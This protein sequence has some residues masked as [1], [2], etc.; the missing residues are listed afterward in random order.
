MKLKIGELLVYFPYEHIYPEQYFYITDL[1]NTLDA[2]GHSVLEMPSGTGKTISLLSLVVSYLLANPT[3]YTKL[4]YCSRTVPELDKV[5]KELQKLLDYITIETGQQPDILGIAL[6]S[7]KNL[8]VHPVVSKLRNSEL[9]NGKCY[10][11]TSSHN[12]N[13]RKILSNFNE[14]ECKPELCDFFESHREQ[15]SDF[16]LPN[17]VYRLCDVRKVGIAKGWCP[18]FIARNA[19]HSANVVVYSYHYLLDPK[20]SD[21]VS[22]DIGPQTVVVFDEAHN[23][24]NVCIDSMSIQLRRSNLQNV[25]DEL[26][27]VE[28]RVNLYVKTDE[29]RMQT[30]YHEL[31][32]K[33]KRSEAIKDTRTVADRLAILESSPLPLSNQL[34]SIQ[35]DSMPGSI[36]NASH[37]IGYVKRLLSYLKARLRVQHVVQ[38][39]P[40][41]FLKDLN[42][43]TCIERRILRHCS[44]RLQSLIRTLEFDDPY[45]LN[46][47]CRLMD[48]ATLVSS[49]DRGFVLLIDPLESKSIHLS[50]MDAS[51]AIKPVFERFRSV[52]ITSGTLSPVSMYPKIL[53]FNPVLVNSLTMTLSRKAICPVIVS[54]GSDQLSLSSRF[55]LRENTAVIRNYGLL[56]R[57]LCNTVP[58][59][60][61]CFFTSYA[62]LENA[63]VHWHESGI[64]DEYLKYKLV[65]IETKDSL[66]TSYA[67][68]NYKRACRN[69]RGAIMLC[70]ARGKV[71]EGVDFEHNYGRCVVMLGIP[72]VYTE[73]QLLHARLDYL[74]E[75]F[76]IHENDFLTFDAMRHAAQCLGRVLR[77]KSDYGLMVLADAR[78]CRADKR[79]KLPKWIQEYIQESLVNV[80][81]DELILVAKKWFKEIG[82]ELSNDKQLGVSILDSRHLKNE[83]LMEKFRSRCQL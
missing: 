36:R 5:V 65:F 35:N 41:A 40:P 55:D 1:K 61:V 57:D 51:L 79:H 63:V 8:C 45:E 20:I 4:V 73:S 37:F 48:F 2:G 19:I 76:Q 14:P 15:S 56:L 27:K 21:I 31:I 30:E 67:L 52:V 13:P 68:H 9:I 23:I 64:I 11:L 71:A 81:S 54:R 69:G 26:G 18:Y 77:A 43:K 42:I 80:S 6:S 53:D 12:R 74:R 70:V 33:L 10:S 58:D 22:R 78:F 59:G 24:D 39:S 7:R 32:G 62:Y 50:C 60:I 46:S 75:C 16:V 49:F 34:K 66:E 72:Y 44:E 28:K 82:Q 83:K 17:G 38:E 29:A 3:S 25:D 47:L